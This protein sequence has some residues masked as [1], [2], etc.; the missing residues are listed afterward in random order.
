MV[1]LLGFP[2]Q[3]CIGLLWACQLFRSM[4]KGEKS[5][6]GGQRIR[7]GF[8][9]GGWM[10]SWRRGWQYVAAAL[11]QQAYPKQQWA[12]RL[13]CLFQNNTCTG[14]LSTDC[15]RL[16]SFW[17]IDKEKK[18]TKRIGEGHPLQVDTRD[19]RGSLAPNHQPSSSAVSLHLFESHKILNHVCA[20]TRRKYQWMDVKESEITHKRMTDGNHKQHDR[21]YKMHTPNIK[22]AGD[23]FAR[24]CVR[25]NV[26]KEGSSCGKTGG[27]GRK[28]SQQ[29]G[30]GKKHKKIQRLGFT[31]T[32]FFCQ[33]F[34]CR[35]EIIW[36]L[37]WCLD[38]SSEQH[39]MKRKE[40]R[41]DEDEMGSGEMAEL[42]GTCKPVPSQHSQADLH[43][44]GWCWHHNPPPSYTAI[45]IFMFM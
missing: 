12:S 23:W 29:N 28:W 44:L 13:A 24:K 5:T 15:D 42:S 41:N 21:M 14:H 31:Q 35:I 38:L 4:S 26:V 45:Y 36:W 11:H 10:V 37:R 32:P 30:T 40:R 19:M 27:G 3:N 20:L 2:G 8:S 7:E 34:K 25:A 9:H 1:N 18:K 43:R 17:W 39:Q 22:A 16:Q 6:W 33:H